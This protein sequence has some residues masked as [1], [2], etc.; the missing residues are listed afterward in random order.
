MAATIDVNTLDSLFDN[1]QKLDDVFN[2]IFDEDPMNELITEKVILNNQF[3]D[4]WSIKPDDTVYAQETHNISYF[5]IPVII[6]IAAIY[7]GIMFFIS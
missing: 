7:Y 3:D 6:E 1:Q 4:D 5:L 2:S